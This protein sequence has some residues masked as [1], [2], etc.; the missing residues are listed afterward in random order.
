MTQI[1]VSDLHDPGGR[2]GRKA[3]Q[4]VLAFLASLREK[5][6]DLSFHDAS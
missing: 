2:K 3:R 5:R 6:E 4:I 1:G